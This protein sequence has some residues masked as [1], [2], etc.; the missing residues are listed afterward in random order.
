MRIIFSKL[1]SRLKR[2]PAVFFNNKN[3]L[4]TLTAAAVILPNLPVNAETNRTFYTIQINSYK[5][6]KD[7]SRYFMILAGKLPEKLL[8]SLRIAYIAPYYAIRVGKFSSRKDALPALA[9][10]KNIAPHALLMKAVK[11]EDVVRTLQPLEPAKSDADKIP[12]AEP[13]P[14]EPLNQ[15]APPQPEPVVPPAKADY[16]PTGEPLPASPPP[17]VQTPAP[18]PVVPAAEPLPTAPSLP[19]V[20]TTAPEITPPEPASTKDNKHIANKIIQPAHCVTNDC[21][22]G[23]RQFKTVHSPVQE[24]DCLACHKQQT[25]EHPAKDGDSF[26][27]IAQ[28]AELCFLCHDP[29]GQKQVVHAPVEEGECLAC[30]EPHGSSEPF[31]LNVGSNQK[32]LCLTCHDGEPFEQKFGHGPVDLGTCTICHLPHESDNQALLRESP[33]ETCLGCHVDFASGMREAPFIHLPV[34]E[35]VCTSCHKPHGSSEANLLKKKGDALCFGCHED[36]KNKSKKARTKHK[37]LYKKDRCGNCH[38]THF[39]E[40]NHLLIKNEKA[41]CLDCHG[42]EDYNR[43]KKSALRNIEKEIKG[44]KY[45][46]GPV[47]EGHCS[48]CHDPHGSRYARLLRGAYPGTF[49]APYKPASYNFCFKCHDKKILASKETTQDTKFRNGSENL[50]YLHVAKPRKGRTCQSCHAVHASNGAKLI[51]TQGAP[52]GAWRVPISFKLTDR[53]GSCSPGCHRRMDYDR[54]KAIDNSQPPE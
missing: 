42:Q 21:H 7:A 11:A 47:A 31:L 15:A 3:L 45:L 23:I 5:G 26:T 36:I 51:D 35:Q 25:T 33:Q 38:Q 18:V 52:F 37:A 10:V 28:G 46:H 54:E 22:A 4:I 39:S 43:T 24:N 48:V 49:Y 29:F 12:A 6:P 27:L 41:L 30:H 17:A 34:K 1:I 19:V 9:P 16:Q 44:K 20:Q 14:P 50:H 40:Q 32:S 13:A 2:I 8:P 53:G